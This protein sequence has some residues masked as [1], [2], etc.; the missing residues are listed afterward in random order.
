MNKNPIF[1]L[2]QIFLLLSILL[3]CIAGV[4]AGA[5]AISERSK[6]S[7]EAETPLA[8]SWHFYSCGTAVPGGAAPRL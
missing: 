1:R 8:L 6:P 2:I 3:L 7:A 4:A 5:V